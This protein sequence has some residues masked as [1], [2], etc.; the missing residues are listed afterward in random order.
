MDYWTYI[1]HYLN[2]SFLVLHMLEMRLLGIIMYI[3][4][5]LFADNV[6]PGKP[7]KAMPPGNRQIA[8]P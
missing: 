3:M 2:K 6:M 8:R 7:S 1:S 4:A 5:M